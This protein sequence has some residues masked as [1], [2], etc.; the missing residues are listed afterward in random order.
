LPFASSKTS[1]SNSG[2]PIK[3]DLRCS[4]EPHTM[5]RVVA[6]DPHPRSLRSGSW[7]LHSR[8]NGPR[9]PQK[10]WAALTRHA[11]SSVR[12]SK[13]SPPIVTNQ[14]ACA[15]RADHASST[16][17]CCK[18]QPTP[19]SPPRMTAKPSPQA[20]R[21]TTNTVAPSSMCLFRVKS[22]PNGPDFS[23]L[24]EARVHPPGAFPSANIGIAAAAVK[25]SRVPAPVLPCYA[26]AQSRRRR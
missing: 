6:R 24:K 5:K 17:C 19:S 15:N 12:G 10:T 20:T 2:R 13:E 11:N 26:L 3:V 25:P 4:T 23:N 9:R 7:H 22:G 14:R 8:S 16:A 1:A 18:S 21:R